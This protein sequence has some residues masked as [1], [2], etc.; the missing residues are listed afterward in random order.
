MPRP[1]PV[2]S[3]T[4][5][6]LCELDTLGGTV[7]WV[8]SWPNAA[9]GNLTPQQQ[10]DNVCNPYFLEAAL[11]RLPDG[12]WCRCTWE[13]VRGQRRWAGRL[14]TARQAA[15]LLEGPRF[16]LPAERRELLYAD[17]WREEQADLWQ[18]DD[19]DALEPLVRRLLTYMRGRQQADFCDLC[20]V[21]WGND[22]AD[23]TSAAR[24]TATSKANH[25]LARRQS[26]C[27]LH[28]VRG[29]PI[30]RWQ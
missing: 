27:T 25:F 23:V 4:D 16:T 30:L 6:L 22:C 1:F 9:A 5:T 19:W 10:N 17:L 24:E 12:R 2:F 26:R 20:P 11:V 21:V 18:G 28:K 3:D 15:E 14:V 8:R 13:H 7:D 29:A